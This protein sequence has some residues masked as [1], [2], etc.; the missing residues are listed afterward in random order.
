MTYL[1]M[2]ASTEI[3]EFP[4][5]TKEQAQLIWGAAKTIMV[6]CL[7]KTLWYTGL[8]ISEVLKLTAKDLRHDGNDYSLV[9]T[10]S[11]RRKPAPEI[12]PI[13]YEL[14][15]SLDTYIT[16]DKLRPTTRLFPDHENTYRYQLRQCAKRAG[17]ENWQKIHPH[18]FRHGFIYEKVKQNL[19]PFLVSKLVGHSSLAVTL[20]YYQPTVE[21]MRAAMNNP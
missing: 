14:G 7:V 19:H 4:H 15:E 6:K 2:I 17:L 11:K 10:R 21:D 1:P 5:V 8:R 9:I 12:F 13:P 18:L 16:A 3:K 20:S